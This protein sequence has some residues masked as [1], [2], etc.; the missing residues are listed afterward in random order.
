LK[1]VLGYEPAELTGRNAFSLVHP[2]DLDSARRAFERALQ[3]PHLRL[4]HGLRFRRRDGSWCDIEIVGHNCLDDPAIAGV[5]L[6]TRDITAR[7]RA[8]EAQRLL[9]AALEQAV[10]TIVITDVQGKILY[11][12]P[13]FE[14]ITGYS[15]QEALGA[16]PRLLKS[17]KHDGAFYTEMWEALVNGE[18]WHGHFINKRKDGTLYEEDASITPIRGQA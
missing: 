8:E 5:V 7:K 17:G 1:E 15:R 11:A 6:S 13:A 16:N 9:A 2:E 10:E 3:H 14:R 18:V 12:N 4:T